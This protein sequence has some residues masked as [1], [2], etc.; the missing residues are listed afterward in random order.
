VGNGA[1]LQF[2]LASFEVP[3]LA[4]ASLALEVLGGFEQRGFE[5]IIS[6]LSVQGR[7]VEEQ[8]RFARVAGGLGVQAR[9]GNLQADLYSEG[10]FGFLLV[11]ENHFGGGDREN[12]VQVIQLF[13]GQAPPNGLGCEIEVS[14]GGFYFTRFI[15]HLFRSICFRIVVGW[16]PAR[17]PTV[18]HH[19]LF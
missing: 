17:Q 4:G 1:K 6:G 15:H 7:A 5:G 14:K 18:F 16:H 11:F 10:R 3:E 8:R 13:P 2:A 9:T 19:Q 12:A